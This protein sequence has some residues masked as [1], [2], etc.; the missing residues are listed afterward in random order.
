MK[1][2][3]LFFL[4]ICGLSAN[5]QRIIK[6]EKVSGYSTHIIGDT[7]EGAI[8]SSELQNVSHFIP[9]NTEVVLAE[10]LLP[11]LLNSIKPINTYG[12]E[13]NTIIR[14][15]LRNYYRQYFG[16]ID[17]N[18]DKIIYIRFLF[19]YNGFVQRDNR[20]NKNIPDWQKGEII[21]KDGG[22]SFWQIKINLKTRSYFDYFV[23]GEA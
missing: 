21:V 4:V 22:T 23:N 16:Y 1:R 13:H 17:K 12:N 19:K 10:S 15:N 5:A 7:F 11:K 2:L 3:T 20:K 6:A 14:K 8:F 18:G 9:S